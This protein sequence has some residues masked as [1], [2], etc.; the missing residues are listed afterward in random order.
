LEHLTHPLAADKGGRDRA[1]GL[2]RRYVIAAFIVLCLPLGSMAW[3]WVWVL[4]GVTFPAAAHV[5]SQR[6]I[7]L[8]AAD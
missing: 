2:R 6:V 8:E 3:V 1:A 7:A 5:T 4:Q